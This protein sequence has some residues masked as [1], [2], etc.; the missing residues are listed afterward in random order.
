MT[1]PG[2]RE[3]AAPVRGIARTAKQGLRSTATL[4]VRTA[5]DAHDDRIG[6]V[7]A[8]VAFFIL[9]S[10]PP[11]IL[12]LAGVAGYV[13]DLLGPSAQ[14]SL[15]QEIIR[16]MGSFLS[17]QT[18]RDLVEP[19]I[20]ELF[21]QGRGDILSL[22]VVLALWSASRMTRVLIHTINIAYDV[23]EWR[24]AWR[25]RLL[26]LGITLSGILILA[27]VLP[28]I[29]AGPGL[30]DLIADRF[31]LPA[32]FGDIW[33][34]AYWPT[35]AATG[36][37]LLASLYHVAP[38]WST[39]WRRDIPGALL[40]G[41][42]WIGAAFGLR[43]YVARAIPEGTFGPLAAP[44]ILMLWLYVSAIAVLL[45]AEFNAELEKMWPSVKSKLKADQPTGGDDE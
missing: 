3:E 7:A 14:D 4:L 21:A 34:I 12:I 8:E 25:R 32:V 22:G 10:L 39:P 2:D 35:A 30:G 16:G 26:S 20:M 6:G 17:P 15:Q 23:K 29:V 37:A 24:S 28:F 36:I 45:G 5:K 11:A 40:A 27:V 1:D 9:L 42:T 41:A 43:V 19:A 33:A 38:N 18:M 44:V 31:S 13:G